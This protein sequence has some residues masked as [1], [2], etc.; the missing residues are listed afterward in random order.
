MNN[1]WFKGKNTSEKEEI[2]NILLNSKKTLDIVSNLVYNM[3]VECISKGT[4]RKDF[5][6]P[7]WAY[8][9]AYE[10]GRQSAY[11]QLL[12]L[13]EAD[14]S[15]TLTKKEALTDARTDP[16]SLRHADSRD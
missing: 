5:E 11:E 9:Q 4:S 8:Q 10:L 13:L 2:K 3:Y 14:Q 1:L 6:N 16:N 15:L 7:S 12:K